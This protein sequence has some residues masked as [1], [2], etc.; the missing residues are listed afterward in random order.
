MKPAIKHFS[1]IRALQLSRLERLSDVIYAIVLWRLFV[2][3]PKPVSAEGAW[4]SAGEYI[5]QNGFTL[6][7]V[8]IGVVF[9][10][11]YWSQ[12]NI[13]LGN[14]RKSDGTHTVLSILQ[15]FALLLFMMSLNMGVLLGGSVFT[16]LFESIMAAFVGLTASFAWMYGIKNR[17]L[18]QHDVSD[19][20]ARKI[21]DTVMAE[22]ITALLT[23]PFAFAGPWIWEISWLLLF[24]VGIIMKRIRKKKLKKQQASGEAI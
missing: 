17:R 3:I 7:V 2:L 12:S 24:P 22:P 19:F 16:R 4:H 23:I 1:E 9:V 14:L 13:L 8:L 5:S 20:D 18:L 10:I 11:I 6:A 21:L 15:L